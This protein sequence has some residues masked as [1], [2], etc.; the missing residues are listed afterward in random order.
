VDRH[1]AGAS[2]FLGIRQG[3]RS[4]EL[5]GFPGGVVIRSP[6]VRQLIFSEA[7]GAILAGRTAEWGWQNC[8]GFLGFALAP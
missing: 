8:A 4:E 3:K 6:S 2:H 7:S 5:S 1:Q